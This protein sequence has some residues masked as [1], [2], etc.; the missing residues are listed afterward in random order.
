M[1]L[2]SAKIISLTQLLHRQLKLEPLTFVLLHKVELGTWYETKSMSHF[3][4]YHLG[5]WCKKLNRV[6][7]LTSYCSE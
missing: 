7:Y 2:D 4:T 3:K 5:F 1:F 6:I